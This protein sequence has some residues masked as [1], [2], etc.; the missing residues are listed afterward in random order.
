MAEAGRCSK[1]PWADGRGELGGR[2]QVLVVG[3]EAGFSQKLMEYAVGFAARMGYGITALSAFHV[4]LTSSLDDPR[5][6]HMVVEFERNAR[7]SARGFAARARQGG[8]AFSHHM[9][10]GARDRAVQEICAAMGCVDFVMSDPS[11]EERA[12][13]GVDPVIPVYAMASAS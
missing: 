11:L 7:E 2:R 3:G 10:L 13:Q 4:P 5:Y 6:A 1:D 12:A 8:V 9:R